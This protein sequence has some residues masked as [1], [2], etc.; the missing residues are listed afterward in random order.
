MEIYRLPALFDNYIF[1]L[2]DPEENSAAVIDPGEAY[3]VLAEL[4]RLNVRLVAIF[5]THYDRDHTAGNRE[6]M[7]AFPDLVVYGGERSRGRIPGQ[8]VFL[9]E[10]DRVSFGGRSAQVLDLPG[11]TKDHIAYY[12]EPE[13]GVGELFC[14]DVLFA[15]GCGR[16]KEGTPE[17]SVVAL[18]RLRQLP[19]ATR[20][21]CA[22]E[23][24]EANLRFAIT[25]DPGNVELKARYA[26]VQRQPQ[27]PTIPTMLDLE[28]RTNPFLRWDSPVIQAFTGKR[29]RTEVFYALRCRKEAF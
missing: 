1:L 12:F 6:L 10:G 18:D 17:Q 11:H 22:H 23:Y 4:K 9:T 19:D 21:W 8:Q 16:V 13:N 26:E 24:T 3:P 25:V 28:K 29:D 7:E 15:G 20:V 2:H 27:K 14:G 5:N